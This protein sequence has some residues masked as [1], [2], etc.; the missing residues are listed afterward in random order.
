MRTTGMTLDDHMLY[1]ILI[2]ALPAE[3]EVEVRNLASRDSVDRDD[4]IK[5]VRKRHHRLSGNR[6]KVFNA[7]HA[8]HAMFA[9]E[10]GGDRRKGGGGGARGK[11]EDHGKG[12]GGRR[13]QQ[14]R[15]GKATNEDGGGS[16]AA[17]GG[18]N[19]SSAKAAEGSTS[20]VTCHRCAMQHDQLKRVHFE[21][22]HC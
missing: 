10:G 2:D 1:T 17:D 5:A 19:D 3:Y 9:G 4:I 8:D 13:G 22:T 11:G 14:G 16:A 12:K 18:G 15:G 20:E 21:T 7:G 6:K